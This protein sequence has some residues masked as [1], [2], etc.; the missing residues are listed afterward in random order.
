MGGRGHM[1]QKRGSGRVSEDEEG[2]GGASLIARPGGGQVA[3]GRMVH[4][5][6]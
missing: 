5:L 2:L 3:R 1:D 4:K 6:T